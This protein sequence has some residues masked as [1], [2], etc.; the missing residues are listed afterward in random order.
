MFGIIYL[1]CSSDPTN[2]FPHLCGAGIH[3]YKY[4]TL[5]AV[6][7]EQVPYL[8][9]PNG[10]SDKL[11]AAKIKELKDKKKPIYEFGEQKIEF[12]SVPSADTGIKVMDGWLGRNISDV[13][14]GFGEAKNRN[15]V[16]AE[17]LMEFLR[18]HKFDHLIINSSE[19]TFH[20][21]LGQLDTWH[22]MQWRQESGEPISGSDYF[23]ELHV[24]LKEQPHTLKSP[25]KNKELPDWF[26]RPLYNAMYG[27][28]AASRGNGNTFAYIEGEM[29]AKD[30][31]NADKP[32]PE[33]LRVKWVYMLQ[34]RPIPEY[35][36]GGKHYYQYFVGDHNSG[37]DDIEMLGM[38]NSTVC[39]GLVLMPERVELLH[40]VSEYHT[41][42]V[43]GPESRNYKYDT[44]MLLNTTNLNKQQAVWELKNIG[45]E[46]LML[47]NNRNELVGY[48]NSPLSVV[49]RPPRLSYR[50]L[51]VEEEMLRVLQATLHQLGH[52]VGRDQY[53]PINVTLND[54]TD[55]F[56]STTEAKGKTVTKM[57]DFYS[58]ANDSVEVSLKNSIAKPQK[59]L[60]V[61]GIDLPPRNNMSKMAEENPKVYLVTWPCDRCIFRYATVI[62][63]DVTISIWMGAYSNM[64]VVMES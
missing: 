25:A 14:T 48:D 61:R 28:A 40:Q 6:Y 23:K 20:A 57:T 33:A 63:T 21:C 50:I 62:I 44:M 19:A 7:F 37:A 55:K 42:A 64:R 24:L 36:I 41:K 60:L 13:A 5:P 9:T 17:T 49:M 39:H 54:Y 27:V 8:V 56:F 22:K 59:V 58:N 46:N 34:N 3:G 15:I 12:N 2:S 31:W 35:D 4:E 26:N 1:E 43:W 30:Y 52:D 11:S 16:L 18:A 53:K 51:E 45:I 32:I 10:Y 47:K 29:N 38:Q